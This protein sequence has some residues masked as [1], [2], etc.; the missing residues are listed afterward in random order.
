MLVALR[1]ILDQKGF[2][3]IAFGEYFELI[4]EN[5]IISDKT[6]NGIF[7]NKEYKNI[8]LT[9]LNLTR[10]LNAMNIRIITQAGK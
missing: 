10:K 8:R 2:K 4:Y 7:I 3:V 6:L 1:D 9:Y 5:S